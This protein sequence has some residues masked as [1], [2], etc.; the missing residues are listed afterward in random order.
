M[1]KFH[2]LVLLRVKPEVL[3]N[4]SVLLLKVETEIF[5]GLRQDQVSDPDLLRIFL[6]AIQALVIKPY[7]LLAELKLKLVPLELKVR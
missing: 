3:E 7:M 1:V 2:L 4:P 5:L 6:P